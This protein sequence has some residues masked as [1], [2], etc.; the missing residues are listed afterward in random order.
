MSHDLV[1][2]GLGRAHLSP[3]VLLLHL[4]LLRGIQLAGD[5]VWG[6]L[7]GCIHMSAGG[8]RSLGFTGTVDQSIL[9]FRLQHGGL[10]A[11]GVRRGS[12]H[13]LKT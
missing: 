11:L 10:R 5:L 3:V 9:S 4:G 1:G 7:D 8:G 13:S 12:C 6:D 2:Q